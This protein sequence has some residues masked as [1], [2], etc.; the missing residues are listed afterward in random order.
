LV[1]FPRNEVTVLVA[2][3]MRASGTFDIAAGWVIGFYLIGDLVG[4]LWGG[5]GGV[6]YIAHLAGAWTGIAV[7]AV[8]IKARWIR[9]TEYE[10]NLLEALGLHTR[11]KKKKR[12]RREE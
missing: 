4:C 10:E 12:R 5:G 8:L 3:A 1:F 9:S 2:Y 11:K 6:A 7:G